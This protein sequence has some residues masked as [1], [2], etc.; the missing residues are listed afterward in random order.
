VHL[1]KSSVNSVNRKRNKS[2]TIGKHGEVFEKPLYNPSV[3]D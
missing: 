3:K 2:K 1:Y